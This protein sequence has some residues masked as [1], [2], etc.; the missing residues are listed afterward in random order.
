VPLIYIPI[1]GE[2]NVWSTKLGQFGRL[3]LGTTVGEESLLDKNFLQ[4]TDNCYAEQ[5]SS[6]ICI[7]REKWL[8]LKS[9]KK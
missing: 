9:S 2:L 5:D 4:R 7:N 1:F 3:R 8:D 6:V